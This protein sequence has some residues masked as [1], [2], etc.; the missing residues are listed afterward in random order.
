[1]EKRDK[2]FS[3]YEG[4]SVFEILLDLF[5]FIGRKLL[6]WGILLGLI[7][8]TILSFLNESIN[9]LFST[10]LFVNIP[11]QVNLI[12]MIFGT[13]IFYF[14]QRKYW[15]FIAIISFL[16]LISFVSKLRLVFSWTSV[17]TFYLSITIVLL[18]ITTY[19]PF[20]RSASTNPGGE[21]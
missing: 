9:D 10:R 20:I 13:M 14:G 11:A 1:M 18:I 4:T 17:K 15:L 3:E 2:I 5:T 8:L 21:N 12:V 19:T 7:T 6:F 16:S